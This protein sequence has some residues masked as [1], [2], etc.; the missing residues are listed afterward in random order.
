[1]HIDNIIYLPRQ[2]G[3]CVATPFLSLA[4]RSGAYEYI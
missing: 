4:E 3:G 1:M 2:L